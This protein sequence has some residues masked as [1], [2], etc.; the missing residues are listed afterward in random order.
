MDLPV[1]P[2]RQ[3][4]DAITRYL[5]LNQ[6]GV[7]KMSKAVRVNV[8][9]P[10]GIADAV[11]AT[12]QSRAEEGVVLVLWETGALTTRDAAEELGLTYLGFLAKV[13]CRT[14]VSLLTGVLD[15]NVI[16]GLAKG[17]VFHL[18]ALVYSPLY[19]PTAVKQEVLARG[20]GS[21][22]APELLQALGGWL[23]E[24]TLNP[25]TLLPFSAI[26]RSD[27]DAGVIAVALEKATDHVLSSDRGL[28]REAVRAGLACV[29][30][31]EVVLLFKR[32]GLLAAVK[33]ILDQMRQEGFGIDDVVYDSTL[34]A[35]G[36]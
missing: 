35:A 21:P 1:L 14:P 7:E 36:E 23:T 20:Q 30:A 15:T 34:Q 5:N 33:P 17:G 32:L 31:T 8:E 19:V 27:A 25:S 26:L 2:W 13:G 11:R 24:I 12:A 28:Y 29:A 22:G 6:A 9:L 3:S 4:G 16:V 18:L 10:E